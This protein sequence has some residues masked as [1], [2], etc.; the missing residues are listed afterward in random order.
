MSHPEN[1][2]RTGARDVAGR[3]RP[4]HSGNPGGRPRRERV[5]SEMLD[6]MTPDILA[7]A[8]EAG[9]TDSTADRKLIL[10]RGAPIPRG[11]TT[12]M[13]LGAVGS[14]PA[15]QAAIQRVADAVGAGDLA[16]SD[17]APLLALIETARRTIESLDLD[18]RIRAL[19]ARSEGT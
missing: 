9:M 7:R 19:E 4:G 11:G 6:K 8:Y 1:T 5:I 17:A 16:P 10:D 2:A 18:A 12:T 14:L 13:D 15:C 3:F